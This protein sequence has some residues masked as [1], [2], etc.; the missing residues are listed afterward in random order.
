MREGNYCFK[1]PYSQNWVEVSGHFHAQAVFL[2]GKVPG[3]PLDTMMD[4]LDT[5][6]KATCSCRELISDS[7]AV[8]PVVRRYKIKLKCVIM[9]FLK[10]GECRFLWPRPY[11][12]SS[13]PL[14]SSNLSIFICTVNKSGPRGS[15][16]DWG[17]MLQAGRS[18]VPIPMRSLEF[19][20][21]I[22]LPAALWSWG[23]LSL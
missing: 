13:N 11:G 6:R 2:P 21:D 18:R 1:H 5:V 7:S 4:G 20:I 8:Q 22:I 12:R 9:N 23:R 10:A 3:Y 16:V 19:S 14:S 15:V 17:T